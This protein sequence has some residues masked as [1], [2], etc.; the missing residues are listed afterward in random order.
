MNDFEK[1]VCENMHNCV[2]IIEEYLELEGNDG[3]NLADKDTLE[4]TLSILQHQINYFKRTRKL[5]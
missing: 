2:K 4:F 1:L 3:V 5:Q